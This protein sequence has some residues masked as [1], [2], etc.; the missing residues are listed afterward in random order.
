MTTDHPLSRNDRPSPRSAAW[1]AAL[2]SLAL[3]GAAAAQETGAP[4]GGAQV[5]MCYGERALC[6]I[7]PAANLDVYQ[8][9]GEAGDK[10]RVTIAGISVNFGPQVDVYGPGGGLLSNAGC[11]PP[12]NQPCAFRHDFTLAQ[13]GLHTLVVS[14]IGLN[15]TSNYHLDLQ[16][17]VPQGAVPTI[18]Y[19]ESVAVTLDHRSDHDWYEFEVVGGSQ[20]TLTASG[21]TVNMGPQIEVYDSAGDL[22]GENWCTPP[23][24]STCSTSLNLAPSEDDT[25][26]AVLSERGNDASG[27]LSFSL[28][29]IIGACP[30]PDPGATLG[31]S[32]CDQTPN[33]T[34]GPAV[35][36]A[37]GSPSVA[38]NDVHLTVT[39]V[40]AGKV[41]I[42]FLG[43][44]QA[45]MPL[46]NSH[47]P[48]CVKPPVFR[49]PIVFSCNGGEMRRQ[50]DLSL[51]PMVAPGT[52]WNVQA[53]F[54]D[55]GGVPPKTT[56]TSDG[57]S[58]TFQ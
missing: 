11:N 37:I 42:F 22:V 20:I 8:F 51:L 24:N 26:Y 39:G 40:P 4:C 10:V 46:Q 16:R 32:Y 9:I 41:G 18:D 47:G 12:F 38:V 5:P 56:N 17:M 6:D 45:D 50:L 43:A 57:L 15:H 23:F 54:R 3:A 55:P 27:A 25:W 19:G 13:R 36:G 49:R 7:A 48:L 53:W 44:V 58:I 52:T 30:P 28:S 29:C 34:G 35:I 1:R 21:G 31:T 2:A 14:D 33:S